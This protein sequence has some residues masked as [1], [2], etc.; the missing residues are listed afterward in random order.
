L[1]RHRGQVSLSST[2]PGIALVSKTKVGRSATL[3]SLARNVREQ[4][5]VKDDQEETEKEETE[6]E[7][8]GKEKDEKRKEETEKEEKRKNAAV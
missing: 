1:P 3:A 2:S 7:E 8:T 4:D 6:K 5:T